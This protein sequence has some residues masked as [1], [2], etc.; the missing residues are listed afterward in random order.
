MPSVAVKSSP[1]TTPTAG[2]GN[3][4]YDKVASKLDAG[5]VSYVYWSAEKIFGELSKKFGPVAEAAVAD[6]NLTP[7]EKERLR[8]SFD[9][10]SRC[11]AA[12]GIQTLKAFGFSS[13]EA[14]PGIFLNKS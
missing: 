2:T 9:L 5:G 1:E 10:A 4:A 3:T 8:K 14:E 12:S 11:T 7:G 6:P 13:K